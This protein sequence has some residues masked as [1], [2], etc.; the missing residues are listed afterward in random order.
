MNSASVVMMWA[1]SMCQTH[2]LTFGSWCVIGDLLLAY[3]A[4]QTLNECPDIHV[5]HSLKL[6]TQV[7]ACAHSTIGAAKG[8]PESQSP[9]NSNAA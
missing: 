3:Q 8:M 5:P 4:L 2:A 1:N 7:A 9:L 6:A